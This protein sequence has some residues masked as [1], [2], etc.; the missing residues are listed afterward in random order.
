[1]IVRNHS[2]SQSPCKSTGQVFGS[3]ANMCLNSDG[4]V[5]GEGQAKMLSPSETGWVNTISNVNVSL[6]SAIVV[7]NVNSVSSKDANPATLDTS[8]FTNQLGFAI[9]KVSVDHS[10]SNPNCTISLG[11]GDAGILSA[12]LHTV[13]YFGNSHS[14]GVPDSVLPVIT[15]VSLDVPLNPGGVTTGAIYGLHFGTSQGNGFVT[16]CNPG[17]APC[18]STADLV[19]PTITYW[20]CANNSCQINFSIGA[21]STAVGNYDLQVSSGGTNSTGF[22]GSSGG[23]QKASST[24]GTIPVT[25]NSPRVTVYLLHGIGQGYFSMKS[26]N[27][28]LSADPTGLKFNFDFGFNFSECSMNTSCGQDCSIDAGAQKLAQYILQNPPFGDIVLVGYSMGGLIARDMIANNYLVNGFAG[29]SLAGF[30]KGKIIGLI[31]LGTPNLG[32]PYDPADESF[33]CPQLVRDMSGSWLPLAVT[34][35]FEL[36]SPFLDTLSQKWN[37]SFGGYWL[38]AAG[39]QSSRLTR[40]FPDYGSPI[41]KG[42]N[43]PQLP[44]SP[45]SDGVVCR[46]SAM[47]K[48]TFGFATPPGPTDPW[49]DLEHIY[50]H[51]FA[52]Y[53]W[54]TSFLFG[55]NNPFIHQQMFDPQPPG[56][57]FRK[58]LGTL[59]AH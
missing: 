8:T 19:N 42:C 49:E 20:G 21:N 37:S 10:H 33:F 23:Q 28:N 4:S 29:S 9:Y 31:T 6:G 53:G 3:A 17:A 11:S 59:N 46:D 52:Y 57:L 12:D 56:T 24:R 58:V 34:P 35:P 36:S 55:T 5:Y 39:T 27:D 51:T 43:P 38:A 14:Y 30:T 22:L 54:G 18:T 25:P 13:S 40:A 48:S 41:Q 44:D 47:Y 16:V 2:T 32:Y 50:V 15:S 26:L 45:Y 1:M 7:T